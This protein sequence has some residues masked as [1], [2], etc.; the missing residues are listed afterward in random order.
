MP[1]L[2]ALIQIHGFPLRLPFSKQNLEV[3]RLGKYITVKSGDDVMIR[4][5]GNAAITLSLAARYMKK[6]EGK[7]SKSLSWVPN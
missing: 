1:L 5:D 4:Y 7:L 3:N 6:V 2:T